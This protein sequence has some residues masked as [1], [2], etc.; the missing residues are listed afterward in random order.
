VHYSGPWFAEVRAGG[1]ATANLLNKGLLPVP[2]SDCSWAAQHPSWCDKFRAAGAVFAARIERQF[3][4]GPEPLVF[5]DKH[6][7]W[8][9]GDRVK[10]DVRGAAIAPLEVLR[11]NKGTKE[12]LQFK[13]YYEFPA[14]GVYPKSGESYIFFAN[15]YGYLFHPLL[16]VKNDSDVLDEL[17]RCSS[18]K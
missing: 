6:G 15:Y 13:R 3:N 9:A 11:G 5:H 8:S 17:K 18:E 12:S 7:D 10:A 1:C 4:P 2:F 14:C 16:I